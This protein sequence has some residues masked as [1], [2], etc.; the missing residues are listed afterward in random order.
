MVWG[1][2]PFGFHLTNLL[3]HYCCALLLAAVMARA[4]APIWAARLSGLVAV[5]FPAGQMAVSWITGRQDLLCGALMLLGVLLFVFWLTDK[6]WPYLLGSAAAVFLAALAKEPGAVA[7]LIMVTA[8][9]LVPGRRSRAIGALGAV[10]VGAA[11]V[12]YV[13]L[14]FHAW[15]PADY[16][17]GNAPQLRSLKVGVRYLFSDLLLPRPYELATQWWR[18]GVYLPFS[19]PWA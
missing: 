15:T 9:L 8:A 11:L 14:R 2:R 10:A 3:L 13:W 6:R 1:R 19:W 17:A 18:V 4:R 12:G 7:P 16:I 5:V